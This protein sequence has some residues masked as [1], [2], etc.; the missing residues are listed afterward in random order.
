MPGLFHNRLPQH[1]HAHTSTRTR[2]HTHT[3]THTHACRGTSTC[4]ILLFEVHGQH[5][6]LLMSVQLSCVW[7]GQSASIASQGVQLQC[8]GKTRLT[9]AGAAHTNN[10]E[11]PPHN[12]D[13][14]P[15]SYRAWR[16]CLLVRSPLHLCPRY[17]FT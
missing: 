3:N 8:L 15:L 5:Q 14:P 2:T 13:L 9:F 11:A 16:Q 12:T 17:S 4:T 1:A 6:L 10:R 7:P